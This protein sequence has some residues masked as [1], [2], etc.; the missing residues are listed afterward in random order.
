MLIKLTHFIY[1]LPFFLIICSD[2]EKLD[3]LRQLPQL[4]L[5][6]S[7]QA[8]AAEQWVCEPVIT[9]SDA[10]SGGRDPAKVEQ[11]SEGGAALVDTHLL[12]A[13][14]TASADGMY[15]CCLSGI[16]P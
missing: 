16:S 10:A 11:T 4:K 3:G 12:D 8:A 5:G 6:R 2:Q 9:H 7:L 14:G 15:R 1:S 13:E